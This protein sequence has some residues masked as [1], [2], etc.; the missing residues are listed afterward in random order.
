MF[1]SILFAL[2]VLLALGF[3]EPAA[4]AAAAAAVADIPTSLKIIAGVP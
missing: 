4:A 3:T 1:T 2:A